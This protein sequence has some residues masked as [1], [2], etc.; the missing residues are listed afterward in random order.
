MGL[1]SA[2]AGGNPKDGREKD[3]FYPSPPDVTEAL[4][5]AETGIRYVAHECAAGDGAMTDVLKTYCREV[6]S[7][8][9]YPKRD[10]IEVQDFLTLK[11]ALGDHLVTNPPFD[12][13]VPFIQKAMDLKYKQVAFVLKATFWHAKRRLKLFNTFRPTTIYPLT[14]RPDFM[15][16]G[17]PTMDIIWCVWDRFAMSSETRYI[18]LEKPL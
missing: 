16:K 2:M 14:W 1:G 8:D 12:L 10:D 3:D 18:P 17:A 13:A 4:L 6:V 7:T 11:Y 5:R 15:K 9:L